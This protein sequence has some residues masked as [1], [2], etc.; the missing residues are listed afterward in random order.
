MT[1]PTP[2]PPHGP[3]I[4]ECLQGQPGDTCQHAFCQP[5]QTAEQR[6]AEFEA[7]VEENMKLFS[8]PAQTDAVMPHPA[9][10]RIAQLMD[11]AR[12]HPAYAEQGK[13]MPAPATATPRTQKESFYGP[14]DSYLENTRL[15]RSEFAEGLER[16][17]QAA[18]AEVARLKA[19]WNNEHATRIDEV[20][21][22]MDENDTLK[23]A[24]AD[25]L[26]KLEGAKA[27]VFEHANA[28]DEQKASILSLRAKLT[29]AEQ[30]IAHDNAVVDALKTRLEAAE[31]QVADTETKYAAFK[32]YTEATVAEL[33]R[34]LEQVIASNKVYERDWPKMVHD[35]AAA[36]RDTE[37]MA[38][39]IQE[40]AGQKT[41][42]EMRDDDDSTDPDWQTGFEEC[43]LTAR[44][45][46]QP[47]PGNERER[48]TL[49]RATANARSPLSHARRTHGY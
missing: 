49:S 24:H 5:E 11:E 20:S 46:L 33:T 12:K 26:A 32:M 28:S 13:E 25:T 8:T 45:A 47:R 48:K 16:D 29:T 14:A 18:T 22:L 2:P 23:Q 44:K 38:N 10:A 27:K 36:R 19:G 35:L 6:M 42:S 4:T 39:A 7:K 40:I 37:R 41:L 21:A 3:P 15:C 1:P 34:E 30:E 9:Q 31:Q 17:L 43:V